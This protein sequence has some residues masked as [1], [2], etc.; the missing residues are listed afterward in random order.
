M[1]KL[2]ILTIIY[3]IGIIIGAL[4]FDVWGAETTIIKTMS[5]F[6]WTILFLI[7]LFYVDKNEKK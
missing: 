3:T 6:V 4:I 5:I 2:T 1:N 7:T